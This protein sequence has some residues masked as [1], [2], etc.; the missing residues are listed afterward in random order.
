MCFSRF[1]VH[2]SFRRWRHRGLPA[3]AKWLILNDDVEGNENN[4]LQSPSTPHLK[5]FFWFLFSSQRGG[6]PGS[7]G[8]SYQQLL[9]EAEDG[10][11]APLE[12]PVLRGFRRQKRR[13]SRNIGGGVESLWKAV[14]DFCRVYLRE[15]LFYPMTVVFIQQIVCMLAAIFGLAGL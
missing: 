4:V 8:E 3:L 11:E 1:V 2:A 9:P 6:A 13:M 10:G 14:R 15:V 7:G 12:S 5:L